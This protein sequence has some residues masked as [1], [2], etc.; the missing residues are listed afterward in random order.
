MKVPYNS[1]AKAKV[2]LAL[3]GLLYKRKLASG[4][5]GREAENGCNPLKMRLTDSG[6]G[7]N[8]E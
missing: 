3:V 7:P 2:T 4:A 6:F 8:I 1:L 5:A